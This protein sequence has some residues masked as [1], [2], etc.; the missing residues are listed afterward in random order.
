MNSIDFNKRLNIFFDNIENKYIYDKFTIIDDSLNI[1]NLYQYYKKTFSI[2]NIESPIV[3]VNTATLLDEE[4]LK[5]IS[6]FV[7]NNKIVLED[8]GELGKKYQ[9]D[10]LVAI[11]TE[12]FDLMH[13]NNTF[14]ISN[15]DRLINCYNQVFISLQAHKQGFNRRLF[16]KCLEKINNQDQLE[17]FKADID[18]LLT[19]IPGNQMLLSTEQQKIKQQLFVANY[20]QSFAEDTILEENF[21]EHLRMELENVEKQIEKSAALY[22]S[23]LIDMENL[24]YLTATAAPHAPS[25]KGLLNSLYQLGSSITG[26]MNVKPKDLTTEEKSLKFNDT[27]QQATQ[28]ALKEFKEISGMQFI[29][30]E[31]QQEFINKLIIIEQKKLNLQPDKPSLLQRLVGY[32]IG[33]E[34]LSRLQEKK[35]N[36]QQ[37]I[38]KHIR[39]IYKQSSEAERA[40][41]DVI[42]QFDLSEILKVNTE[43]SNYLRQK[44]QN[45]IATCIIFDS[46]NNLM[47]NV[48]NE[49]FID[50]A[51]EIEVIK[52]ISRVEPFNQMHFKLQLEYINKVSNL[53]KDVRHQQSIATS[54]S[55]NKEII[56][57][58]EDSVNNI[59]EDMYIG[60]GKNISLLKQRDINP[61]TPNNQGGLTKWL[62]NNMIEPLVK[63]FIQ[64]HLDKANKYLRYISVAKKA[65]TS[66]IKLIPNTIKYIK[67]E[68]NDI[69]DMK[70]SFANR[71]FRAASMLAAV[72]AGIVGSALLVATASNPFSGPILLGAVGI[73]TATVLVVAGAAKLSSIISNAVSK[74][75]YG[76]QNPDLY[77]PNQKAR[78]MLGAYAITLGEFLKE[79]IIMINRDKEFKRHTDVT[80]EE[81]KNIWQYALSGDEDNFF[82]SIDGLFSKFQKHYLDLAQ[83]KLQEEDIV[84]DK[85]QLFYSLMDL[86]LPV[87][88]ENATKEKSE[89]SKDNSSL[90]S[91]QVGLQKNL[92]ANIAHIEHHYSNEISSSHAKFI[93]PR[94]SI[95]F[96]PIDNKEDIGID[97]LNLTFNKD[98]YKDLK[99]IKEI[100]DNISEFRKINHK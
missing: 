8:L 74:S 87:K 37:E 91:T 25:N 15:I 59:I 89:F 19:T 76:V 58:C 72:G 39:E 24:T 100:S 40:F 66:P 84:K 83:K 77:V 51:L 75:V 57:K 20:L 46:N 38:S 92:L 93:G 14:D 94:R 22:S 97:R 41:N 43:L 47:F 3:G 33:N 90:Q 21:K 10:N 45:V 29:S 26:M 23:P 4:I 64:P 18:S 62:Y 55:K 96:N 85:E 56:R 32:F 82:N 63:P 65:I 54:E 88:A 1:E 16:K 30:K 70:K 42:E 12:Q 5:L 86:T 34:E 49:K 73:S 48:Q 6:D 61:N 69:I 99:T 13:T 81:I 17:K 52:T 95:L 79:K 44:I 60:P 36:L 31:K 11:L 9:K 2:K 71:A 35:D 53:L 78:N 50:V 80:E 7:V 68:I 27:F 28:I 98:W 67:S